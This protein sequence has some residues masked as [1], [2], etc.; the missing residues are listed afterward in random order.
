MYMLKV[1]YRSIWPSVIII[2]NHLPLLF[3]NC[4]AHVTIIKYLLKNIYL[5]RTYTKRD[6]NKNIN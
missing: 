1:T 3:V 6:S 4:H 2:L 5:H